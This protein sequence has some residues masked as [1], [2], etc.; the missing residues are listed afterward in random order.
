V[1][2]TSNNSKPF[3]ALIARKAEIETLLARLATLSAERFN[4]T[5][6]QVT[7]G[8]VGTLGSYLEGLREVSDAT[9]NEGEHAV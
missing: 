3:E 5:P 4:Q 6:D 8:D 7:W 1:S 2:K 9:F